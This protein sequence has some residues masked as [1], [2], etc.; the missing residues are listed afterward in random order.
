[1]WHELS[2]IQT[3]LSV[4]G[5]YDLPRAGSDLAYVGTQWPPLTCT[6]T[7]DSQTSTETSSY[8]IDDNRWKS[9]VMQINWELETQAKSWYD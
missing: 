8:T 3:Y 4:N 2:G 5:S 7:T 1:M 9:A 6:V